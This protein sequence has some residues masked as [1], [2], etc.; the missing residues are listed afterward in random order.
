MKTV[1]EWI[2]QYKAERRLFL[3]GKISQEQRKLTFRTGDLVKA[4]QLDAWKQGASDI[5]D[6]VIVDNPVGNMKLADKLIQFRA[7]K[8]IG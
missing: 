3:D 6:E 8:Q 7:T 5:I 2:T 4:I 1:S